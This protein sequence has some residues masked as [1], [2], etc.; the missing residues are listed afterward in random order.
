[1]TRVHMQFF[2]LDNAI[3]NDPSVIQGDQDALGHPQRHR[4]AQPWEVQQVS[5]MFTKN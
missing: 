2:N 5:V 4:Q 3:Q 1:M